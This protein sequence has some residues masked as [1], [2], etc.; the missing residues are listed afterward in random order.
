M[1][2]DYI[3]TQIIAL[4]RLDSVMQAVY[5]ENIRMAATGEQLVPGLQLTLLGDTVQELWAPMLI[6]FDQF[7]AHSDSTS[8]KRSEHRLRGL[9]HRDLPI[10]LGDVQAWVHYEDS[11]T[12]QMP[13]R[14]GI[15]GRAIR[16]RIT[17][18]RLQYALQ[19]TAPVVIDQTGGF[20]GTFV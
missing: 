8:L 17:P 7:I 2:W 4:L 12:L 20:L 10:Q 13:D 1:M 3:I 14:S 9:F 18:L 5:G 6:Q 16:F 15:L 19:S 11:T